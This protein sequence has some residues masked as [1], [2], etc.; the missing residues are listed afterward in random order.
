M[1]KNGKDEHDQAV[2]AILISSKT[3]LKLINDVLDLS[4]LEASRMV[5]EPEPTDC[6]TLVRE[7]VESF[8]VATKKPELDIRADLD[9]MPILLL[10]DDQKLNLMVLK[11]MLT[12]IGPF[13]FTMAHNGKEAMKLLN[14]PKDPPFDLVLTDIWMPEMDGASLVQEIRKTPNLETLP[15]YAITADI[16]TA[17]NF[18]ELGFSGILLKPVTLKS[19]QETLNNVGFC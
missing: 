18:S 5:I 6:C 7:I 17:K 16:E 11:A 1:L 3:L 13:H 19:L 9:G 10:V 2:D 4:K 12:K 14:D 15:V 8:R